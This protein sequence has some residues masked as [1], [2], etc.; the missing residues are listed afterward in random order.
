MVNAL[1]YWLYTIIRGL[2]I[3]T[4]LAIAYKLYLDGRCSVQMQLYLL[5]L[6]AQ[7]FL[8]QYIHSIDKQIFTIPALVKCQEVLIKHA[9]HKQTNFNHR[10]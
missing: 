9:Y 1:L 10:R 3:G 6:C 8:V 2:R 5:K 7:T 4:Y